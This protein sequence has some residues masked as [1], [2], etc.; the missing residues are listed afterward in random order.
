MAD[1]ANGSHVHLSSLCTVD[2]ANQRWWPPRSPSRAQAA[3]LSPGLT[4]ALHLEVSAA[5]Q[6]GWQLIQPQA[7][8]PF[9]RRVLLAERWE[10]A[11]G[12]LANQLLQ[13]GMASGD[14]SCGGACSH[15]GACLTLLTRGCGGWCRGHASRLGR[16]RSRS[17]G[18]CRL[19]W[20]HRRQRSD[21]SPQHE[22]LPPGP[23]GPSP[24]LVAFLAQRILPSGQAGQGCE[25]PSPPPKSR[26]LSPGS[27]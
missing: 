2:S 21:T 3:A 1:T 9:E 7:Q 23:L 16:A 26:P 5:L 13:G 22:A 11:E 25:C 14:G 4:C 8:L 18:S 24:R 19:C 27:H 17:G 20:R 10:P 6:R 12:A 15:W